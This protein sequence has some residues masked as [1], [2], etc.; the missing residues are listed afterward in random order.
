MIPEGDIVRSGV[1]KN[2]V[3]GICVGD[4]FRRFANY[5][6]QLDFIVG[7]MLGDRLYY[8]GDLD[9]CTRAND[10]G[11]GFVE[12]DGEPESQLAQIVLAQMSPLLWLVH[13]ALDLRF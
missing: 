11:G 13:L 4:V 1:R 9:W 3:E 5:D 7:K 6:G 10:S 12:Q 8:L 2:V